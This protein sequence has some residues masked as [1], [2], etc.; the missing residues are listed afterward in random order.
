MKS[1]NL[2]TTIYG[3]Q[4]HHMSNCTTCGCRR[5]TSRL[6]EATIHQSKE[7]ENDPKSK[8]DQRIGMSL[9]ETLGREELG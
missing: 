6:E 5:I 1:F 4:S 3:G 2:I 8:S 7:V 9:L